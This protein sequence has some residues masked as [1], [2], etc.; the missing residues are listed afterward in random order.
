[1]GYAGRT[2]TRWLDIGCALVSVAIIILIAV[3]ITSLK[4]VVDFIGAFASAY[5]S[6]VLPPIW[7]IAVR[8]KQK[9][10]SWWSAENL[11]CLA[12]FALGGFFFSFGT[13]AAVSSAIAG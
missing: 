4:T 8:H 11:L 12:L 13:Y 2:L 6:Y 7:V 10:L 5:I 9:G 1:M 3:V